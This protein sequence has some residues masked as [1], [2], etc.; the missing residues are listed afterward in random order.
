MGKST[1][2]LPF[3]LLGFAIT[4]TSQDG[5]PNAMPGKCYAKCLIPDQYETITEQVIIKP[6][7]KRTIVVPAEFEHKTETIVV[8]AASK[9]IVPV[10]AVFETI[11]EHVMIKPESKRINGV[12]AE[13]ETLTERVMIK[14]ETKRL[15]AVPAEYETVTETYEMEAAYTKI[16][17]LQPQFETV[18]ERVETKP[19][20]TKWMKKSADANCLSANPD[21][22]LVWCLVETP[23]EYQTITKRVNKGCDGSGIAA[24]GC[25]R[26]IEVPAKMGTLTVH[27]VKTPATTREEIVPAEYKNVT[28]HKLKTPATTGG[29]EIPAEYITLTKQVVKVPA[30]TREE[31]IPAETRTITTRV[32][33]TPSTTLTEDI[34][35]E[36]VTVTKRRLLKPGE[37]SEW[38]EI[39]CGEKV[40]GYTIHQIQAALLSAGYDPGPIDNTMG[41]RTKAALIKFQKDKNLPV[42]NLDL[43]TLKALG[44]DF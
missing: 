10:P 11:E 36:T 27:K 28:V 31:E 23:A 15:I 16:E 42:G 44:V 33:K 9:R 38:R 25:I 24:A 37:F 3:L 30:T 1:F 6:A 21:D 2:L 32:V 41:A 40:T 26:T 14:P 18:T 19:A 43:E 12:P 34:P 39:L 4:A 35:A 22:C 13:F 5:P 17:V 29:V 8:K 7:G 20:S